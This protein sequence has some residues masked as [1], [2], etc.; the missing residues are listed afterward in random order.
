MYGIARW[1]MWTERHTPMTFG[2]SFIPDYASYLGT[3][4]QKSMDAL[5]NDVGVRNFRLTSYWNDI[6]KSPG[7]YDFTQLDWEF[8]KAEKSNS[9]VILTLGLRQPRWP[10]CHAPNWVDT[11]QPES[12]WQPQLETF[13]QRVI[14]RYKTSPALASYQL[15]NEFFLKGFGTC[16]NFNRDRLVSEYKLIKQTDSTHP[17]IVGRS[18]NALG[19][20]V[21]EPTPDEFSI[22][23]YK[24]VWDASVTH[25]YLE[26]PWPAWYYGF[27]AGVQKI[28]TGK[29]MIIAELQG[30]AWPPNGQTIPAASLAEQNKSLNAHRLEGR[31]DYAKATGM[32]Q[33]YLWGGEYW[34]YR[35]VVLHDDSLWKVAKQQFQAA[36]AGN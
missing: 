34:Y 22:S 13:M 18:N 15:E 33:A 11:T 29:D 21:G 2:V 9:R 35:K 1:Y 23:V 28:Y 26:Y 16:T 17:I 19:F 36:H 8:Q 3:D 20:P 30:E 25:R 6:E 32:K 7:H 12:Q 5:I 27:L 31:F 14:N 10:E 24:R 4:P